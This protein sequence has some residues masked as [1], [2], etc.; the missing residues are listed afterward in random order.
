MVMQNTGPGTEGTTFQDY[1]IVA[2][3]TM[4]GELKSLK[5][6]GSLDA[7]KILFT[8]PGRHEV[9]RELEEQLVL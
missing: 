5:E 8:K 7:G 2:C 6:S 3:G 4:N 1:A 9:P